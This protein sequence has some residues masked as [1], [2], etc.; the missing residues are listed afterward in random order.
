LQ[1]IKDATM[2]N[3][4]SIYEIKDVAM[5]NTEAIAK[6]EGQLGYLVVEFNMNR[7]RRA[8]KS[9]DGKRAIHD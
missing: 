3:S 8:S 6:L 2:V 5:A 1:E 7:G 4:Q 9:G